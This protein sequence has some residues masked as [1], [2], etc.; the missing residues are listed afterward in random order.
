MHKMF[1]W[2][3]KCHVA[4]MVYDSKSDL[5]TNLKWEL[6]EMILLGH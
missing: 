3:D 2:P 6:S 5:C 4:Y 1:L